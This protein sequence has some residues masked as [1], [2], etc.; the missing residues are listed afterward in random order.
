MKIGFIGLGI[1]GSRMAANLQ[2][3]GH[4]LIVHNRTRAKA[5]DLIANGATW[6][7]TPAGVAPQADLLITMLAH[8][9]AVT[10]TALGQDGFLDHLRPQTIWVDSST[11]NPTFSR[12]MAAEATTRDV[13]FVDAPVAGSKDAAAN[14]QLT[15]IVGG[16]AEIVEQVQPLFKVMGRRVVHVG[17]PGMGT[18]LKVVVNGQLAIAMAAFAEG[19]VLGQALGIDKQLLLE[20]LV[21]SPVTAPFVNGKRHYIERRQYETEFPLKWMHKDLHL[22]ALE[23]YE[24]SVASPLSDTAKALYQ[25]AARHGLADDDFSAIYEFML[26]DEGR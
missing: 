7:D 20:V 11:V 22:A 23:S 24:H 26:T 25:L 16:A 15:F 12:Q 8:P 21:G 4:D 2:A 1:M 18:S 3:A 14:A 10:Q 9:A 6:A 19:L 17:G 5:Q 13:H